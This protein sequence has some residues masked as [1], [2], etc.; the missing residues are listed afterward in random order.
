MKIRRLNL[1]FHSFTSTAHELFMYACLRNKE[2]S[3]YL[4]TKEASHNYVD[5]HKRRCAFFTYFIYASIRYKG[6]SVFCQKNVPII[7]ESFFPAVHI[8]EIPDIPNILRSHECGLRR[9]MILGRHPR[10]AHMT[11]LFFLFFYAF[12]S[13]DDDNPRRVN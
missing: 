6:P 3:Y 7:N 8:F 2:T 1:Y 10:I 9:I 4:L 12:L 5:F 13:R 11:L